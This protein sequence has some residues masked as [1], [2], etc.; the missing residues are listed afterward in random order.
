MRLVKH[1]AAGVMCCAAL[2]GILSFSPVAR[3]GAQAK[4]EDNEA[5]IRAHYTNMKFASPCATA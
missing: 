3:T 2:I 5:E 4:P 1:F